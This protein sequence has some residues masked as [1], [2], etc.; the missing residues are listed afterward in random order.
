MILLPPP[1]SAQVLSKIEFDKAINGGQIDLDV[2]DDTTNNSLT[3]DFS[4]VKDGNVLK[5]KNVSGT[6]QDYTTAS[7]TAKVPFYMLKGDLVKNDN[8]K[9]ESSSLSFTIDSKVKLQGL[10]QIN[11]LY[12][13]DGKYDILDEHENIISNNKVTNKIL[14]GLNDFAIKQK[15]GT[16]NLSFNKNLNCFY[17]LKLQ[18]SE[19]KMETIPD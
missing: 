17:I 7:G 4:F 8:D 13:P 16:F 12:V 5:A 19:T 3:T 6:D 18:S 15:E 11:E 1:K 14:Y 10:L 9:I 2:T